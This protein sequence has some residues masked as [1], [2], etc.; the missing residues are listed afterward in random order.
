MVRGLQRMAAGLEAALAASRAIHH[1][2]AVGEAREHAVAREL[3]PHFPNRFRLASG[4]VVN[5]AGEESHQQDVLVTDPSIGTPFVAEGHIGVH[6]I[7]TVAATLQIKTTISA[8]TMA[9]A[10]ENVS[11]VKRLLPDAP[12]PFSRLGAG[13]LAFGE[14]VM[15]PFA[16]IVAFENSSPQEAIRRAF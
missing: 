11:S 9:E 6:P 12:R 16:A 1:N 15:K 3:G 14:A 8:S 13:Q 2:L 4:I 5:V 10:V 7:E